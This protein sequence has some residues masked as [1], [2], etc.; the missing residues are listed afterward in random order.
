MVKK[1][2]EMRELYKGRLFFRACVLTFAVIMYFLLPQ[3]FVVLEGWN[4]FRNF[5][6]LHLLWLIW[7]ID[8]I[9]QLVPAE[10]YLTIGSLK[11]FGRYYVPAQDM[12]DVTIRKA[13]FRQNL[14]DAGLVLAVWILFVAGIGV[15]WRLEIL[16]TR[17]L[18][19]VSTA[20]Y[21]LDLIFVLYWCP[22]R[23]WFL[24]NRCCTTCRIFNW[25]HLMMFS[26]IVFVPGFFSY[27]LFGMSLIV[28]F[29]WEISFLR[30]SERFC[31]ATNDALKCRNCSEVLCGNN[32]RG[33]GNR[34]SDLY[35]KM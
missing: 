20:F 9:W 2:F 14:L 4:F 7:V 15:L 6:W 35:I 18:L 8:M 33:R 16:Q 29:I 25:D 24:R 31:E 5:S 22:F 21:V 19:L 34:S 26:P 11:Q 12:P 28:F 1:L 17:E 27:S 32:L 30:H 13:I 10:G 3:S 23:V